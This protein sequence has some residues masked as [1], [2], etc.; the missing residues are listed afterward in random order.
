MKNLPFIKVR[1]QLKFDLNFLNINSSQALKLHTDT[2]P[3]RR[4]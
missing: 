1:Q 4:R 2:K 3:E